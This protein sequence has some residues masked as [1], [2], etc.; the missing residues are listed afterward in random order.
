MQSELGT[1]RARV[2][3]RRSIDAGID[4]ARVIPPRCWFDAETM[5]R[6]LDALRQRS[7]AWSEERKL[8]GERPRHGWTSDSADAFRY[9]AVRLREPRDTFGVAT[10]Q[11]ANAK[12]KALRKTPPYRLRC[13]TGLLCLS[14]RSPH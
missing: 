1:G 6:E 9:L 14:A 5:A 13:R 11:A 3:K 10:W 8:F 7:R 12:S 4:A 2:V